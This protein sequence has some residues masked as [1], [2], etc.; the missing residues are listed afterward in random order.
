MDETSTPALTVRSLAQVGK[1][2]TS[3]AVRVMSPFIETPV[4]TVSDSVEETSAEPMPEPP[5][6]VWLNALTSLTVRSPAL[7]SAMPPVPLP[8]AR[9]ETA[10]SRALPAP[11]PDPALSPSRA[12][13]TSAPVALPSVMAPVAV[14]SAVSPAAL[15]TPTVKSPPCAWRRR[16][17]PVPPAVTDRA[18]RLAPASMRMTPSPVL[19]LSTTRSSTSPIQMPG[20]GAPENGP[21]PVVL[22]STRVTAVSIWPVAPGAPMARPAVRNS[23]PAVT[24]VV[25]TPSSKTDPA[26]AVRVALAV[27][28]AAT[29]STV[30]SPAAVVRTTEFDGSSVP[31]TTLRTRVAPPATRL[32]PPLAVVALSTSRPSSSLRLMP[33]TPAT[34]AVTN[35]TA[36]SRL[37]M[38]VTAVANSW[39]AKTR[40]APAVVSVMEP[41]VAVSVTLPRPASTASPSSMLAASMTMSPP[42]APCVAESTPEPPPVPPTARKS[43]S[44][45]TLMT[46]PSVIR[47]GP[48]GPAGWVRSTSPAVLMISGPLPRA[49]TPELAVTTTSPP[50]VSEM[51][52]PVTSPNWLVAAS[53]MTTSPPA[54]SMTGPPVDA[55]APSGGLK[56]PLLPPVRMSPVDSRA[57]NPG[58]WTTSPPSVTDSEPV[59]VRATCPAAPVTCTP[60]SAALT[61]PT[62]R[63]PVLRRKIPPVAVSASRWLT[64][65]CTELPTPMPVTADSASAAAV[66][67]GP[68]PPAAMSPAVAVSVTVPAAVTGLSRLIEPAEI[69]TPPAALAGP[70]G[71]EAGA[72]L[73]GGRGDGDIGDGE[74][75]GVR[76][77][78]VALGAGRQRGDGR[79]QR[80]ARPEAGAGGHYE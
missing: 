62:V 28:P 76:D 2:G 55:T 47:A 70:G 35:S 21:A 30:M 41:A 16:L 56:K 5:N 73:A 78:D 27:R 38:P 61:P 36:V 24:R 75:T 8:Q 65:D 80:V 68:A 12:A 69:V 49:I 10:V 52:T 67:C 11:M 46:P 32:M 34:V 58:P 79:L 43:P 26:E 23:E 9:V 20:V 66:T 72:E 31:A 53:P 18:S 33:P 74:P 42:G 4:A 6:T 71:A 51:P 59:T 45:K 14:S 63:S 39:L 29:V 77:R 7:A 3:P 54:V 57:I 13:V 40:L 25:F 60:D 50:T 17:R 15:T 19:V 48:N 44:A 64:A 37:T 1:S 22:A